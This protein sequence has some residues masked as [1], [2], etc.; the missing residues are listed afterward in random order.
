MPWV[1][2]DDHFD[3]H[4]KVAQLS[5]SAFALFVAGLAYCNR[6]LTDG[7]IPSRVGLGQ[8]RWA[9]GN[10]APPIRELE[11]VGL[12]EPVD[13]GWQV[14][15]YDDYQPSRESVLAEREAARKRKAKSRQKSRRDTPVT[16]SNV[17]A[18]VHPPPVPVP[19]NT[20]SLENGLRAFNQ[21]RAREEAESDKRRGGAIRSLGAVAKSKA[22]DPDFRAESERIWSHRECVTCK[23]SGFTEVYASGAGMVKRE[24]TGETG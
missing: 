12:W 1:K 6:S 21:Q 17:T 20:L 16:D 22:R 4:P 9:D 10:T 3:Q 11:E 2:L 18:E 13:G 19:K 5:D 23:G 14:H 24:C 7:F 8:L 15:D